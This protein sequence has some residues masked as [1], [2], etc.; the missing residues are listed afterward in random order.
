MSGD[1]EREVVAGLVPV[2]IPFGIDWPVF[3]LLVAVK[4]LSQ[5]LEPRRDRPGREDCRVLSSH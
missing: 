2:T 1:G 3:A 4:L 5:L